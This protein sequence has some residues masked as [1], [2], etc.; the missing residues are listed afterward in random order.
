M[1]KWLIN[2]KKQSEN[3]SLIYYT[4]KN[5]VT[6]FTQLELNMKHNKDIRNFKITNEK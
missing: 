3:I 5:Q 1:R 2:E 6:F 4:G